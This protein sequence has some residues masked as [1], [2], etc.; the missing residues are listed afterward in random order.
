MAEQRNPP[1]PIG[2]NVIDNIERLRQERGLSYDALSAELAKIGHSINPV[3]LSRLGRGERRVGADDLVA[4]AIILN[5]TPQSLLF[6]RDAGWD[7]LVELTPEVRQRVYAVWAWAWMTDYLP[8]EPVPVLAEASPGSDR[9]SHER[10]VDF[11]T[12]AYPHGGEIQRDPTHDA[13]RD[14]A[15]RIRVS[16]Q[17]F[18]N[19]ANWDLRRDWMI[20]GL[21]I[22]AVQL[23]ELIARGDREAERKGGGPYN[24]GNAIRQIQE[25]VGQVR[26]PFAN[27]APG[28]LERVRDETRRRYENTHEAEGAARTIG[29]SGEV[30]GQG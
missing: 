18:A 6:P 2:R 1:G 19:P 21:R 13:A 9:E 29:P 20:R 22:T 27:Y 24:T 10:Q 7:D 11:E 28:T 30:G 17:D 5:V 4:F 14:F 12:H 8:V 26:E 15:G 23:E 25:A 16:L 3:S